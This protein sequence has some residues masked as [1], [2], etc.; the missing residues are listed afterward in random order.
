ML[1]TPVVKT[2]DGSTH[3]F[4][5]IKSWKCD[6]CFRLYLKKC[7]SHRRRLLMAFYENKAPTITTIT[8]PQKRPFKVTFFRQKTLCFHAYV[9]IFAGIFSI[10]THVIEAKRFSSKNKNDEEYSE[11]ETSTTEPG[12]Y[13]YNIIPEKNLSNF[14]YMF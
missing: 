7:F 12:K 6:F 3:F 13:F 8:N 4:I 10:Y 1:W 9:S 14:T 5:I 11:E 2:F